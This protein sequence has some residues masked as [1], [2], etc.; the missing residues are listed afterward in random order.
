MG[1]L[2]ICTDLPSSDRRHAR[3]D[4]ELQGDD[5]TCRVLGSTWAV[6]TSEPPAKWYARVRRVLGADHPVLVVAVMS[7]L[8]GHLPVETMAWFDRHLGSG[9]G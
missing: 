9:G 6:F 1:V 4:A 7:K 2:L 3:L 5:A 8:A